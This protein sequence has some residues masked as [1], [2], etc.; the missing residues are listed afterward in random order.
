M[1]TA[2]QIPFFAAM[3][4]FGLLRVPPEQEHEGLDISH[5]GG[6]AYPKEFVK[7]EKGGDGSQHGGILAVRWV[8]CNNIDLLLRIVMICLRFWGACRIW[9]SMYP[10]RAMQRQFC[11]QQ[12]RKI[13]VE[14]C[15]LLCGMP[16]DSVVMVTLPATPICS[17]Q[18]GKLSNPVAIYPL[19]ECRHC[20]GIEGS[21][22]SS[23]MWVSIFFDSA[24]TTMLHD[25]CGTTSVSKSTM[26]REATNLG[27]EIVGSRVNAVQSLCYVWQPGYYIGLQGSCIW[28]WSESICHLSI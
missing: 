14:A 21:E 15:T 6:S 27:A 2:V 11:G 17:Q 18:G 5:H 13:A 12:N 20:W 28:C 10:D 7:L 9:M 24:L 4:I 23:F 3:K 26:E 8:L 22:A 19:P 1:A 25:R 16:C